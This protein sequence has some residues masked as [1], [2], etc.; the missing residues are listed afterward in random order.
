MQLKLQLNGNREAYYRNAYVKAQQKLARLQKVVELNAQ[1][2][3]EA[4]QKAQAN[5]EA[6][7]K[8]EESRSKKKK[9]KKDT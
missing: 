2:A 3:K 1:R 8:L 6:A 7:K 9:K 4:M 5:E